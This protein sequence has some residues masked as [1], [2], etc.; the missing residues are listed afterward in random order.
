MVEIELHWMNDYLMVIHEVEKARRASQDH[1]RVEPFQTRNL[2]SAMR[3]LI[4]KLTLRR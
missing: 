2:P 1:R 4:H 3:R